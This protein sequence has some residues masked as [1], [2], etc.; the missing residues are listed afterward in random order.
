MARRL[1]QLEYEAGRAFDQYDAADP[2]NRLVAGELERRWNAK[3]AQVEETRRELAE[4]EAESRPLGEAERGR[5][6]ALGEHFASVWESER[7]PVEI[8]KKIARALIEEIVVDVEE[9]RLTVRLIIHW[10]GGAHTEIAM[11]KLPRPEGQKTALEDREIIRKM[12]SR[13]GDGDIARVLNKMGR[14]TGKGNAWTLERVATARRKSS[15]PGRRKTELDPETLTQAG[16]AKYAGVS[17]TTIKR[18]VEAGVLEM[19]QAVPWAP[20]EI[21]RSDVDREPVRPILERLHATGKLVL[22]GDDS[23]GQQSLFQQTREV[24]N[25]R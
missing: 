10:K 13:Y 21:R 25:D 8:E 7:C 5:V 17:Q 23:T 20:W 4:L 15:I 3:L 11:P 2:H 19:R 6:L 24:Y 18:L 9:A 22:V 14:R 16:A 12:A 1:E